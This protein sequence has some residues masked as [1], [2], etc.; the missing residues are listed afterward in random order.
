MPPPDSCI[1][2]G[3]V[4]AERPRAH[5]SE[6]LPIVAGFP[7]RPVLI[8]RTHAMADATLGVVDKATHDPS[9]CFRSAHATSS[10]EPCMRCPRRGVCGLR[11]P[12]VDKQGAFPTSAPERARAHSIAF[13]LQTETYR[14]GREMAGA[15]RRSRTI[16]NI[17][18]HVTWMAGVEEAG[19]DRPVTAPIG[20]ASEMDTVVAIVGAVA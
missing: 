14:R 15:R 20:H 7:I 19:L 4:A 2:P 11:S 13:F 5:L 9:A 16:D 18:A 12:V 10:F 17:P 8:K 3:N 1:K 6:T